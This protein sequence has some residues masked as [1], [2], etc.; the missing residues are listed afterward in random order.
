MEDGI[1]EIAM[2][3]KDYWYSQEGGD[4]C[5]YGVEGQSYQWN[6]NNELEWIYDR[7]RRV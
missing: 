2:Q 3:W 4:L 1:D 5:S 7:D 6:E